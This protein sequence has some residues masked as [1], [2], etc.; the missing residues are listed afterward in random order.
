VPLIAAAALLSVL[1]LYQAVTSALPAALL[2]PLHL[3][4]VLALV[5][6]SHPLV[7]DRSA[8]GFRP[9][10]VV[11]AL[12]VALALATGLGVMRFDHDSIEHLL[13]GLDALHLA[14]GAVLIA[15]V[16]EA[17]RRTV[18]GFMA[19]L[20]LV[21]LAYAGLGD[22]LPDAIASRGFSLERIV[23]FQVFTQ[24]GLFGLPLG[25]AAGTVFVFVLLGAFLEVSGA[26]RFFIDL[27]FAAAGR[28]RGGPAKASVLASA[29]MGSISGS[30]IAN[31]VATGSLTIPMMKRLGYRPEQAAGIEAAASTGG[32]LTPPIMGA[33]AFIMAE[34]TDTPYGDLVLLSIGPAALFFAS[35][36]LY[37][38][39][40][41]VRRNLAP[42]PEAERPRLLHTLR[43]GIHYGLPLVLVAV[44]L[45][46]GYSPPLVGA[47]GCL[48]VLAA[49]LLR[50]RTR[51]SV[52]DVV[53]ALEAGARMALPVSVACATAGIVVGVIG[54]TGIGL[55]FTEAV[56]SLAAG[57][58]WPALG[59]IAGAALLLGMGLPVTA[60]YIV[61]AVVAAPA[62]ESMGLA[63]VTAH[64]IV[65]WLSQTSNVTPPIALAAFAAAGIAGASP[66][67]S[68][69]EAFKLSTGLFVVPVMLATSPLLPLAGVPLASAAAAWLATLV[70]I[71]AVAFAA[72]GH[73]LA[74]LA[75]GERACFAAAALAI[76]QP[77][78]LR[79]AGV[80]LAL[81]SLALHF[82]QT[83]LAATSAP[84]EAP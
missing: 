34:L 55:E 32:Q 62:L 76:T 61:V 74:P 3:A 25:I 6:A 43:E 58:L 24:D 23:R 47:A 42:I 4:W 72:E 60:A 15:L 7:P 46:A 83:G 49:S 64:M 12:L 80:A 39:L 35:A 26:G 14:L 53:R 36:L 30:A 44:L 13:H 66:T 82:R 59:L 52:R 54:Q 29:A 33:G 67:R 70:L 18:G 11:D 65:F 81:V 8:R 79:I 9:G 40:M 1:H 37:V 20:G 75:P 57:R 10:R 27:A 51:V 48:S 78:A 69:I 73:A 45:L 84:P 5:F 41:A 50:V 56:V 16:L 68:A 2:R 77:G 28:F 22:R 19:V 63:P 17:A 21:F 38:H 31:T 71:G